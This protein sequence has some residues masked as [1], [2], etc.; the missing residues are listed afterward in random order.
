LPAEFATSIPAETKKNMPGF[1][2]PKKIGT[3]TPGYEA[4]ISLFTA[5]IPSRI[6]AKPG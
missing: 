1:R 2:A 6:F 4:S 5:K 3:L